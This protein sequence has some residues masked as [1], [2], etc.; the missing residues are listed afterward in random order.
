MELKNKFI[1][2]QGDSVTDVSRSREDLT[3]LG[4]G[5][6]KYISEILSSKNIC[7]KILNR[8]VS[9]DTTSLLLKRWN[10]DTIKLQPDILNI[11]IGVNDTW[12]RYDSNLPISTEEFKSNYKKLLD[13]TLEKTNAKIILCLPFILE[14]DDFMK[15]MKYEDLIYK[16]QTIKEICKEYSLPLI[17]FQKIFDISLEKTGLRELSI[18]GIHPLEKGHKILAEYWIKEVEKLQ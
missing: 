10:E 18:E 2:F 13:I 3:D 16:Q 15:K 6:V 4:G 14:F 8:G 9:G 12:R 11:L 7:C 1:L 5:Y 17:D